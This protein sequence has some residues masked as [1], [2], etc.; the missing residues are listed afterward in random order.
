MDG[1]SPKGKVFIFD[2]FLSL[3]KA[4]QA[5]MFMLRPEF[6]E[7]ESNR[8]NFEILINEGVIRDFDIEYFEDFLEAEND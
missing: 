7:L 2:E 6:L 3:V 4:E 5:Y 8:R 1:I